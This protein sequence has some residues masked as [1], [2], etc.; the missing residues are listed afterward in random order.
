MLKSRLGDPQLLQ[1][2][3]SLCFSSFYV[4]CRCYDRHAP[5]ADMQAE[6]T[7]VPNKNRG[8]SSSCREGIIE[9]Q[10]VKSF[11]PKR[12]VVVNMINATNSATIVTDV[13]KS[14]PT[15]CEIIE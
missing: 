13:S 2:L 1:L 4:V 11:R 5:K 14:G 3:Y 12:E 10:N 6:C 15:L 7:N 8:S 9:S